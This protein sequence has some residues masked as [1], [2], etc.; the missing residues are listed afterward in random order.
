[1]AKIVSIF[2]SFFIIIGCN[3][4][5]IEEEDN[6][7]PTIKLFSIKDD[8]NA[9]SQ[10]EGEY[11]YSYD[12]NGYIT[13]IIFNGDNNQSLTYIYSYTSNYLLSKVE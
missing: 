6:F 1:M 12:K 9:D 11:F 13:K 8:I 10:S 5:N 7:E 2:L 3:S 4:N